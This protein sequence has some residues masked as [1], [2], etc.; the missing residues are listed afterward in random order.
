M[1]KPI[2]I[3]PNPNLKTPTQP[4]S[5]IDDE[6]RQLITDLTDTMRQSNGVG[7][8]ANQIG[9]NKSVVV[10]EYKKPADSEDTAPDFPLTVLINPAIVEHSITTKCDEEGCLSVP[11]TFGSVDRWQ[12]ITVQYLDEQGQSQTLSVKDL[13]ARAIQHEM[14][15][16][17]G[18]LFIE[19]ATNIHYDELDEDVEE[20]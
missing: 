6:I 14:D 12:T 16:L 17:A 19:K 18:K 9:S 11:N 5:E 3:A 13:Y 10:V 2:L 7:L 15:H 8:S 4:V 1:I 20:F